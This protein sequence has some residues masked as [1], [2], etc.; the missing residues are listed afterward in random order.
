V[1]TPDASSGR[2][3]DIWPQATDREPAAVVAELRRRAP[4]WLRSQIRPMTAAE[5]RLW[6]YFGDRPWMGA[7]VFTQVPVYLP[8]VNRGFVLGFL[9]PACRAAVEVVAQRPGDAL[10]ALASAMEQ[11]DLVRDR[12]GI[13]TLRTLEPMVLKD[14]KAVAESIRWTLGLGEG[15]ANFHG[16]NVPRP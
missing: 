5:Q 4:A 14:P 11:D 2:L 12:G 8:D 1:T 6:R 16:I 3:A 10:G 15:G 9:V 13:A 7:D